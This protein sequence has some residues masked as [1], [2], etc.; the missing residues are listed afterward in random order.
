MI[1]LSVSV[2]WVNIWT[3]FHHEIFT[4]FM[5]I[6]CVYNVQKYSTDDDLENMVCVS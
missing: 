1:A 5:L 4:V 2:D 6:L 3:S